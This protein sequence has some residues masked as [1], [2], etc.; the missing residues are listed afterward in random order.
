MAYGVWFSILNSGWQHA[1]QVFSAAMCKWRQRSILSIP[2][3]NDKY[4]TQVEASIKA[5]GQLYCYLSVTRLLS[6]VVGPTHLEIIWSQR[7]LAARGHVLQASMNI[8]CN[9]S[10]R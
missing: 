6:E 4:N 8:V 5:K 9:S 1:R 3:V 2:K 10:G 7:E